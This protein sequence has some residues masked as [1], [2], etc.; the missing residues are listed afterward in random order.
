MNRVKRHVMIVLL[1]AREIIQI[2]TFCY[3]NCDR[4][5]SISEHDF[6]KLKG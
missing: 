2:Y 3:K 1:V 4:M 5:Y 6:K